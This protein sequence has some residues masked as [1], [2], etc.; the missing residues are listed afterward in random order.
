MN[1]SVQISAV[2]LIVALFANSLGFEIMPFSTSFKNSAQESTPENYTISYASEQRSGVI[3]QYDATNT[4][5][6]FSYSRDS[7][8]DVYDHSGNYQYTFVFPKHQNG[9]VCVCCEG[10][11]VY[12]STQD[13][14]LYA[15][16]GTTE[17]YHIPYEDAVKSGKD[18][19]WFYHK[20]RKIEVSKDWIVWLDDNGNSVKQIRTPP[21]IQSTLNQRNP[22]VVL[23]IVCA[24]CAWLLLNCVIKAFLRKKT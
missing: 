24:I 17:L 23:L 6:Y 2:F 15:F 13:N 1:I 20:Q 22:Q 18:A 9:S 5:M 16:Q 19:Y 3:H 14:I 10:E 12:I 8:V 4:L 11:V 21:A 7:C